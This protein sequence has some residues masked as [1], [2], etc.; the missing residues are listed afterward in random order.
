MLR[1][2]FIGGG[3]FWLLLGSTL[4]FFTY[5]PA[6]VRREAEESGLTAQTIGCNAMYQVA[7]ADRVTL[8]PRDEA[9]GADLQPKARD[10]K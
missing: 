8:T 3:V 4:Y 5:R 6:A 1:W 7:L 10:R 2:T 9:Y